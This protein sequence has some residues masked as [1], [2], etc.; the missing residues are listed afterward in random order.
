MPTTEEQ[1]RHLVLAGTADSRPFTQVNAGGRRPGP[2][3]PARNPEE[4]GRALNEGLAAI[5]QSRTE[6]EHSRAEWQLSDITGL[7]LSFDLDLNPD[8]PLDSLEDRRSGIELLSFRP[9]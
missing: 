9:S 8:L 1:L 5:G 2:R 7:T 6:L 4:H 3:Y